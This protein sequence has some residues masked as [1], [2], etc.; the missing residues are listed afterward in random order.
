MRVSSNELFSTLNKCAKFHVDIPSHYRLKFIPA[1]AWL[2]FRRR[3]IL[4]TI[5]YSKPMQAPNFGGRFDQ[6][7]LWIF[8]CEIH[9]RFLSIFS[10]P[11]CKKSKMAKKSNQG[12]T[13]LKSADTLLRQSAQTEVK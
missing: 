9:T 11:C 8:L 13:A 2:N 3:P 1:N 12:D 5:L 6:L 4:C 10:I 7:S